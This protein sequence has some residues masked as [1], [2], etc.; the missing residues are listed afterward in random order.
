ML[1]F[2]K[3]SML[4]ME[5]VHWYPMIALLLFGIFFLGWLFY[6]VTMPK[7][8]SKRFSELPLESNGLKEPHYE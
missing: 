5:S 7:E 1:K 4:E 8:D 6:S 3:H 2:I